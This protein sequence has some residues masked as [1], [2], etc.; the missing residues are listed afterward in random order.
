MAASP[1]ARLD[2][3]VKCRQR[4]VQS[5]NGSLRK[6]QKKKVS[7]YRTVCTAD[8]DDDGL[9]EYDTKPLPKRRST[10]KK[11]V[12]KN[13][14]APAIGS[15]I[16]TPNAVYEIVRRLG[17]GG[18]GEV[19]H[20]KDQAARD[21]AMKTEPV[22]PG[23]EKVQPG[24]VLVFEEIAK[25]KKLQPEGF[26][27]LINMFESGIV[28]NM[29]YIVMTLTGPSLNDATKKHKL[30]YHTALRLSIHSLDA[31]DE[32]HRVGLIHRDIK[33]ENFLTSR[34][35]RKL[36]YLADFGM[37]CAIPKREQKLPKESSYSFL[38]TVTYAS[39]TSHKG[40]VQSRKDDIESWIYMCLEFFKKKVLPWDE[41]DQAKAL[42]L[43]EAFFRD[44]PKL[45]NA[46]KAPFFFVMACRKVD[47]C[48]F[49]D[50]PN[51]KAIREGLMQRAIAEKVDFDKLF[52]WE[53]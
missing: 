26:P 48:S 19:F 1:A 53:P 27:H 2:L 51:Y 45:V 35:G 31:I 30:K 40:M 37:C 10:K 36:I 52:D 17:S 9:I 44:P 47:E 25:A 24:E 13:G 38:G 16:Q 6:K 39:R 3:S 4:N 32:F 15:N 33:P 42:K 23:E 12:V 20:V 43:K 18:Y 22:K 5:K 8:D 28:G 46:A 21:Y 14:T 49:F 29:R 34:C 11:K 7:E 41:D 50:A